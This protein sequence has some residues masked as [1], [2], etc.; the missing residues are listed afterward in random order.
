MDKSF[1][2]VCD[3]SGAFLTSIDTEVQKINIGSG[4]YR[5]D[6]YNSHFDSPTVQVLKIANHLFG[7]GTAMGRV[8]VGYTHTQHN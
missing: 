6:P 3:G 2:I 4:S 1:E 7:V 8:W 5:S